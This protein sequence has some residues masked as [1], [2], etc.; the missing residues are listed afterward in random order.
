MK[1]G[2]TRTS[3]HFGAWF[4]ICC[5][6]LPSNSTLPMYLSSRKALLAYAGLNMILVTYNQKSSGQ[7]VCFKKKKAEIKQMEKGGEGILGR[8][9]IEPR[10]GG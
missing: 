9:R 3:Q 5:S 6:H 10:F 1:N 8:E 7:Y 2:E 4:Q